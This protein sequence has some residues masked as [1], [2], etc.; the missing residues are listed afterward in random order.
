[1]GDGAAVLDCVVI[2]GGHAGLTASSRLLQEGIEHVVLERGR[3]GQSWRSQRWDSF[4]L[5]TPGWWDRLPDGAAIEPTDA[6]PLRDAW[7]TILESYAAARRLP[8]REG[9]RV[10]RLDAAP[11]GGFLITTDAAETPMMQSHSVIIASGGQ[12]VARIP[13]MA[14]RLPADIT[15]LD[16]GR[17]RNPQQLPPGAVLVV[18][19]AQ[20]GG[21]IVEDL[22]EGGRRVF[23]ATSRVPRGPRRYRG[24]D[25]LEW[26][27]PAG[28]F[29]VRT[30][31]IR[32]PADLRTPV[33]ILS[34]VGRY[35]HSVSLQWLASRGATLLGHLRDVDSTTIH[36]DRDVADNIRWADARSAEIRGRIDAWIIG[37]GQA[38]PPHDDDAADAPHSDPDAFPAPDR[39]DLRAEGISTVIWSCGFRAD[40]DWLHL[41]VVAGDGSLVQR[42][43]RADF[44][45]VC[46]LGF[47]WLRTRRSGVVIGAKDDTEAV[48]A[49]IKT[50]LAEAYAAGGPAGTAPSC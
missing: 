48:V 39:L 31:D 4:A 35:G 30:Q 47:P 14:A 32:D 16:T 26:L 3:V 38:L 7:V 42:D 5:N 22:L 10:S 23:M 18:G 44:P 28:Y 20:S 8:V 25:I 21:Q 50:H 34:G 29:D 46:F 40:L 43:G 1:M 6:F 24:W 9:V 33:L 36:L 19:G 45:G 15:Q 11:G 41:P 13:A 17:Y 37:R 49:H 12:T 2:G 27:V